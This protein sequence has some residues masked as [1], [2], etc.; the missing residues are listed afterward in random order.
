[1]GCLPWALEDGCFA[2]GGILSVDA[3]GFGFAAAL[4]AADA[5]V[6]AAAAAASAFGSKSL[7]AELLITAL[8][9]ISRPSRPRPVSAPIH[10][11]S[12]FPVRSLDSPPPLPFP[13]ATPTPTPVIPLSS[14]CCSSAAVNSAS[15]K[16]DGSTGSDISPCHDPATNPTVL[17]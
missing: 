1:M 2:C 3:F 15:A 4:A 12:S 7:T 6:A 8:V 10:S 13:S 11:A 14:P 9:G 5:A 16:N 17:T